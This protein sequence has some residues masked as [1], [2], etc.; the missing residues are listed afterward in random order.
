ML[1][2]SALTITAEI[3]F[4]QERLWGGVVIGGPCF[5]PKV[6]DASILML[7][8]AHR[9]SESTTPVAERHSHQEPWGCIFN[10]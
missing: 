7:P 1:T 5:S 3:K 2:S 4:D 6:G 8:P 9:N 10:D